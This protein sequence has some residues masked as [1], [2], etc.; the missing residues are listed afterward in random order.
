MKRKSF[1]SSITTLILALFMTNLLTVC[2]A[3]TTYIAPAP[4]VPSHKYFDY[5]GER[6]LVH[7]SA[8]IFPTWGKGLERVVKDNDDSY[9]LLLKYR[10]DDNSATWKMIYGGV[11]MTVGL[12]MLVGASAMPLDLDNLENDTAARGSSMA[13]ACVVEVIGGIVMLW[14]AFTH[15]GDE[16]VLDVINTF[17]R[18]SSD[19]I[20]PIIGLRYYEGKPALAMTTSF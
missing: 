17:N 12:A 6:H 7:D 19:K 8:W 11:I 16:Q 18:N 14:G 20:T 4:Y 2:F 1:V 10:G 5:Q 13:S 15:P 3:E 9:D